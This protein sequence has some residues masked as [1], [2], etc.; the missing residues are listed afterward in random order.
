MT[1]TAVAQILPFPA[2]GYTGM[3]EAVRAVL[4]RPDVRPVPAN[5]LPPLWRR[6]ATGDAK[7]RLHH[8]GDYVEAMQHML[9]RPHPQG[10]RAAT[11]LAKSF[12]LKRYP[13][14][15]ALLAQARHTNGPVAALAALKAFYDEFGTNLPA[16]FYKVVLQ[17]IQANGHTPLMRAP[18][19]LERECVMDGVL[20]AVLLVTPLVKRL[21]AV[22]SQHGMAFDH[23]M[24]Y[25]CRVSQ[26]LGAPHQYDVDAAAKPALLQNMLAAA[27]EQTAM[28]LQAFMPA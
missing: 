18:H 3:A 26:H 24:N 8:A 9:G 27:Y 25:S 1:Q 22:F 21:Q 20:H 13:K 23:V 11:L 2:A 15:D 12:E 6:I 10:W 16:A 28:R 7:V 4:P 14:L 19:T 5:T 17:A